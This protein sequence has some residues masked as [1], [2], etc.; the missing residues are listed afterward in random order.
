[1]ARR[2]RGTEVCEFVIPPLG[3]RPDVVYLLGYE[4]ADTGG[5]YLTFVCIPGE[6]VLTQ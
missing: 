3:D 1:M 2:T 4:G 6:D 5:L